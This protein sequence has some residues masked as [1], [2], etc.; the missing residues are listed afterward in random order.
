MKAFLCRWKIRYRL[1]LMSARNFTIYELDP[2]FAGSRSK[3]GEI[4]LVPA[5]IQTR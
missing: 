1:P 3:N 4:L 5:T 2:I